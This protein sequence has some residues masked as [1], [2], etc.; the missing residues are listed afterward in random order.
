[1]RY[2]SALMSMIDWGQIRAIFFDLDDT[3]IPSEQ[4]YAA[5]LKEM[6]IDRTIYSE[7]RAAVKERLGEGHVSARNRLLY[8]KEYLQRKRVHSPAEVLQTM[9]KYEELCVRNIIVEWDRLKRD[10][11]LTSLSSRAKLALVTNENL[12][13]QLLK[14]AAMDPQGNYFLRMVTSEEMGVEKPSGKIFLEALRAFNLCPE[15][16]V[17]VGDSLV[18]DINPALQLG[19]HAVLS[20]EFLQEDGWVPKG[21][22][23]IQSLEELDS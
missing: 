5:S 13:T 22:P 20:R 4:I 6:G 9:A 8:F 16:C 15:E 23:V 12:R 14:W 10:R 3:L 18:R 2:P 19:M 7:A 11:L 1:M 21:V 17:V